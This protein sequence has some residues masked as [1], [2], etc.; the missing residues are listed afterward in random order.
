MIHRYL[1]TGVGVLITD[2]GRRPPGWQRKR[3]LP[4]S[5]WWP[6]RD[7][8]LGLP[9][10]R[11]RRADRDDEA[12]PGHRHAAPAGR[13]GAAGAAVPRRPW[14]TAGRARA[15][16][17]RRCRRGALAAGCFALLW[18]QVA[19]GGWVSTNYA[20]LACSDF[21]T[22]QGSWW[23]AMDFAQGFEHRG[24]SWA[25]GR[26]ASIL[27]SPRSRPSTTRTG[28]S[29]YVVFARARPAGLGPVADD[30]ACPPRAASPWRC[31]AVPH[32]SW[33]AGSAM[34]CWAGRWWRRSRT[35]AGAALLVG[36]LT[37]LL[38]RAHA[39]ERHALSAPVPTASS[40]E[41]RALS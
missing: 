6:T 3:R 41:F 28:C 29:A 1:A 23:P 27:P 2:A 14:P 37:A 34:W 13:P 15:S 17:P 9:A 39:A 30:A 22:C 25:T 5:P 4:V 38:T 33:P 20:V 10:G 18:L 36:V 31:W 8:G 11:L 32:G 12:V 16:S 40:L 19:L 24:A 21:P 35:P 7:A 26:T